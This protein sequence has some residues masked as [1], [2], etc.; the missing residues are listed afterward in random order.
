MLAPGARS[1][2]S[3]IS[4]RK[5][6]RGHLRHGVV[7]V[8]ALLLLGTPALALTGPSV[9]ALG[10]GA[11]ADISAPS[12][13][14][15]SSLHVNASYRLEASTLGGCTDALPSESLGLNATAT[16]GVPPYQFAWDFGD[17]SANATGNPVQHTFHNG[18][19]DWVDAENISLIVTDGSGATV[20]QDLQVPGIYGTPAKCVSPSQWTPVL[21]VG[22]VLAAVALIVGILEARDR[23]ARKRPPAPD[24]EGEG[25]TS[26]DG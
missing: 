17:G 24:P 18:G 8:T 12:G 9:T 16:G 13:P 1:L 6:G 25:R 20:H 14:E 21:V 4:R 2:P 3:P 5:G 22:G 7:L 26:H 10:A 15:P 19:A 11:W 23:G